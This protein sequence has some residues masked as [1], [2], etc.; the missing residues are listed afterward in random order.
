MRGEIKL[1]LV[2]LVLFF[3]ISVFVLYLLGIFWFIFQFYVLLM[4]DF[5]N[6][7][8]FVIYIMFLIVLLVRKV[9]KKQFYIVGFVFILVVYILY[10]FFG[11]GFLYFGQYIF[12]WF[13]GFLVIVF[14]VYIIVIGIMEKLRIVD[15][16][17]I[18][19]KM[20]SIEVIFMSFFFFGVV[21]LIM[22]FLCFVGSYFVYVMI[23]FY[24]SRVF[25]FFFLVFY[26]VIF[27]LLLVFILFIMG[28]ILESKCFFQVFV[29]YSRGFLVV[30]GIFLIGIGV[31]VFMG[32]LVQNI[33]VQ[34]Y[35]L[36]LVS[37]EVFVFFILF[38]FFSFLIKKFLSFFKFLIVICIS[39]L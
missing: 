22:L 4:S 20:F 6:F 27:V 35:F 30:V 32:G 14:G 28:S 21:V 5:I 31:W 26:N 36:I 15:K 1:L 37:I 7:C 24:G 11:V 33:F 29:R 39:M 38:M 8:I 2:I 16:K 23:I 34:F 10:Y 18:R 19:K 3:G 12:F 9:E 13:V 25:V 17:G